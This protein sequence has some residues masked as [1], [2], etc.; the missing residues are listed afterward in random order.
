MLSLPCLTS[1]PREYSQA[2]ARSSVGAWTLTGLSNFSPEVQDSSV[3][4]NAP[5][6]T[7]GEAGPSYCTQREAGLWDQP[8]GSAGLPCCVLL[9]PARAGPETAPRHQTQLSLLAL[10]A[11]ESL[12]SHQS[13][14]EKGEFTGVGRGNTVG[15][16]TSRL[17]SKCLQKSTFTPCTDTCSSAG[18]ESACNAGDPGSI[19]ESGRSPGEA[20]GHPLQSSCLVNPMDRG[21][22]QATVHGVARAGQDLAT[23]PPSP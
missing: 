16:Q 10:A 4:V 1:S 23:K 18:K 7:V 14:T 5:S 15:E 12:Q 3:A 21:T 20:N 17:T 2:S 8:P 11:S 19:P 9:A 22:W 13:K 6:H